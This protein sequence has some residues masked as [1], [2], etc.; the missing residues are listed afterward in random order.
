MRIMSVALAACI[1]LIT[2]SPD[3]QARDYW[4]SFGNGN[5]NSG[6]AVCP[7]ANQTTGR[8][9]C[10][11]LSC[12]ADTPLAFSISVGGSS[13]PSGTVPVL[14]YI[15]DM[16]VTTLQMEYVDNPAMSQVGVNFNPEEHA[17]LL[18]HLR[19][20]RT[21]EISIFKEGFKL[22]QTFSLRSSAKEIE[23][24]LE[25]CDIAKETSVVAERD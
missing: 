3:V 5:N 10:L 20:G 9:F 6:A 7:I 22:N 13:L 12:E 24:A 18:K 19:S 2:T 17:E 8:F 23:Y 1:A 14:I 11:A 15:D 16:P 25:I 21:G 4:Q